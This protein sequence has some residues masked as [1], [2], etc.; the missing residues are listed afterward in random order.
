LK[1][2]GLGPR[3]LGQRRSAP[4]GCPC[5]ALPA[6][7]GAGLCR[8]GGRPP[9]RQEA[10]TVLAAV[11]RKAQFGEFCKFGLVEVWGPKWRCIH[12]SGTDL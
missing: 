6:A 8:G 12:S 1:S 4:G 11:G 5:P 7:R 10:L 3:V 2:G 9:G